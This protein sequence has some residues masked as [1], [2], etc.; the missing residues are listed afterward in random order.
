MIPLL[1]TAGLAL[2]GG[3]LTQEKKDS[4]AKGGMLN[5]DEYYDSGD[6]IGDLEIEE[7]EI[8]IPITEKIN[9]TPTKK[10]NGSSECKIGK[11]RVYG[12]LRLLDNEAEIYIDVDVLATSEEDALK[13]VTKPYQ[14]VSPDSDILVEIIEIYE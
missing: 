3:Y 9:L 4:Y 14:E 10:G 12:D 13:K 1:V 6:I 7:S 5:S 11:Y 8:E 2:I